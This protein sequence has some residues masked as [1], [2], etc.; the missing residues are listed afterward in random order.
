MAGPV[1]TE[2]LCLAHAN[3]VRVVLVDATFA[4]AQLADES[5]RTAWTTSLLTRVA[6]AYADGA[7]IDI[8]F[9]DTVG[10]PAALTNLTA[11]T[12]ALIRAANPHAQVSMDVN[13]H[14]FWVRERGRGKG[15][16]P[17]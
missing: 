8:E 3:G 5:A 10:Q 12:A 4:V 6:A 11:T 14:P 17:S 9:A 16:A 1:D 2:L 15:D 7:N 13:I